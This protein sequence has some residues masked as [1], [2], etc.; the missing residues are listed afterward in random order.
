M[1]SLWLFILGSLALTV[2]ACRALQP[3]A[4]MPKPVGRADVAH[5]AAGDRAFAFRLLSILRERDGN[6]AFSP[7][8]VRMAL[9][10]AWAGAG[11]ET[12]GEIETVLGLS[13]D[14][15]AIHQSHQALL[16]VWKAPRGALPSSFKL[17]V[18][19]GFFAQAERRPAQ[20]FIELLQRYYDAP[21]SPKDFAA[22]DTARDQVNRW[23]ETKTSDRLEGFLPTGSVDSGVE[24]MLVSALDFEAP[25]LHPFDLGHTSRGKFKKA[26]GKS[27]DVMLMST[28]GELLVNE[29]PEA[30]VVEL[31]Y[32]TE[33]FVFDLIVPRGPL[34]AFEAALDEKKL[35]QLLAGLT[36]KE[37]TLTLPR[38]TAGDAIE[39]AG[40]LQKI[41]IHAAFAKTKA[42]F[43]PM[44]GTRQL[45]LSSVPHRI[46]L[47]VDEGATAE[48]K[49]DGKPVETRGVDVRATR[50]F[51]YVVRDKK[52][53][54][55][56]ALGRVVEPGPG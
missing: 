3:P 15:T 36:P 37:A 46:R 45:F 17:R 39:L 51:L 10:M 1:R 35:D 34:P 30:Q 56:L 47:V 21:V 26:D 20:A 52:R 8:G 31:E 7:A 14:P 4:P 16:E 55:V 29:T 18:A 23:V 48:N 50:P 33:D 54:L 32:A 12:A 2:A 28:S 44:T 53:N 6:L 25:W 43:S 13:G 24:L 49:G 19:Q 5:L 40:P 42:D 41:G 22:P 38:F 27:A 11:G 9:S